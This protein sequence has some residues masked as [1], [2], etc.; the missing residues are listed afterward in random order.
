MDALQF[1][2]KQRD[3]NPR[4][5]TRVKS[6]VL[7]ISARSFFQDTE[8]CRTL[9]KPAKGHFKALYVYELAHLFT[10][11]VHPHGIFLFSGMA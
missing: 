1:L 5:I 7:L 3:P 9:A 4:S 10:S 6:G 8:E 11:N 2:C